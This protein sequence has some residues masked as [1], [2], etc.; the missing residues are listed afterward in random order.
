MALAAIKRGLVPPCGDEYENLKISV[1]GLDF[2]NPIG[3]AAGFDKNAE[4]VP[5]LFRLG[6]GFVECGTVTPL[7]QAGNPK[8]RVFRLEEDEALINR[9]GFNNVGGKQFIE[10]LLGHKSQNVGI[11]GINIGRNKNSGDALFDYLNLLQLVA[12]Y[13]DYITVNVSSPNTPGL[14]DLQAKSVLDDFL[15]ALSQLKG[16]LK[17]EHGYSRPLLLKIA[18]DLEPAEVEDICELAIKHGIDGLIV[19]N[20]TIARP[21]TLSSPYRGEQGGLSG[22]PLAAASTAMISQVYKFTKGRIVII[23]VGGVSS[24]LDAYNKIRAGASLVQLYTA[25][26]YQGFGV[27]RSIKSDLSALLRRDGINSINE[28]IGQQ[29]AK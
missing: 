12:P 24:G 20:T 26:V 22:R 15:Q 2:A 10:N 8:P 13:A 18:P 1:L 19:S 29:A 21:A 25:L 9:L 14:R 11:I 3:L 5:N 17:L 7:P 4:A 6:F 23:G 16:R 27:V 28:L